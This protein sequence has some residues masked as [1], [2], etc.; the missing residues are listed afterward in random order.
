MPDRRGN[1]NVHRSLQI[2]GRIMARI[3]SVHPGLWTDEAKST[4]SGVTHIYVIQ[5]GIDGP[6]KIGISRNAFWRRQDLQSGNHRALHL[7]ALFAA[8]DRGH[9][10]A[11]EASAL[12]HFS[13]LY[14]S[15]EWLDLSPDVIARFIEEE[16]ARG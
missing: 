9:A 10:L 2:R 11:A 4:R 3:R 16:F 15:G 5:E 14:L 1:R 13:E 8:D 12:T 6:C 7:R